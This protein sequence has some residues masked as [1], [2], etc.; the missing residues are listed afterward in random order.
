MV[1]VVERGLGALLILVLLRACC[2]TGTV[3]LLGENAPLSSGK[4][5]L[6]EETVE[7]NGVN[8]WE[9]DAI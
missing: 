9:L 8:G 3:L 7:N 4:P 5:F 2:S 6:W 1:T